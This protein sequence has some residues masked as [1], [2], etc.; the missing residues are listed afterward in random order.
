M[1]TIE[2][3]CNEYV[4][5]IVD[6]HAE[7]RWCDAGE[8][9]D[10]LKAA[11][12]AGARTERH[13]LLRWRDPKEELPKGSEKVLVKYRLANGTIKYGIGEINMV[14]KF[15]GNSPTFIIEGSCHREVALWRPIEEE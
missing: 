10:Y 13:E 2:E 14:Y 1:K 6:A 4:A 12:E 11:F 3:K 15:L 8:L 5:P 7:C 9:E